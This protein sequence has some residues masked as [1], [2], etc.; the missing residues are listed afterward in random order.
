MRALVAGI[1]SFEAALEWQ[2]GADGV[3]AVR[4]LR[5][6]VALPSRLR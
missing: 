6:P 1:R 5:A 4:L 3:L 2:L